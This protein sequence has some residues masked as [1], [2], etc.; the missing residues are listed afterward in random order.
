MPADADL[1]CEYFLSSQLSNS[2][3]S[4]SVKTASLAT[5]TT[6]QSS[7]NGHQHHHHHH[8]HTNGSTHNSLTFETIDFVKYNK[9]PMSDA[10]KL[11]YE[12][13]NNNNHHHNNN[14]SSTTAITN[15]SANTLN[16]NHSLSQSISAVG[17]AL[18]NGLNKSQIVN[19]KPVENG[20]GK[21]QQTS[22]TVSTTNGVAKA[23][24]SSSTPALDLTWSRIR[25]KGIGLLNLGNNCYLNATLQ[26]LAYTPPLSQWLVTRPHSPQ[27]R[28][29]VLKGF[30][31]LC[32]VERII[33]D[34]FNSAYGCAKPNSLCYNIKKISNLFGVGTQEDASEF[35][36]TLLEH[37]AKAIKFSSSSSPNQFNGAVNGKHNANNKRSHT[38]LD[39]IFAFQFRSRITCSSCGRLS[40]TIED[41]NIWPLEVK[42]VQDIR[43]GMLHFLKEEIL[44][45]ENA[46]K[47]EKCGRKTR[48]TKKYSIRSAP[49]ILVVHLK[50][51]DSSHV[52]KLSHYVA[53]PETLQLPGLVNNNNSMGLEGGGSGVQYKLYGVLVHLGYTSHSGH[54]YSYVRGPPH[55]QQWY[56]ADDTSVSAVSASDALAQNAYILFYSKVAPPPSSTPII[57]TPSSN[58]VSTSSSS[59]LSA[60]STPSTLN[61]HHNHVSL[62]FN[63][64]NSS[65]T[66]GTKLLNGNSNAP[67]STPTPSTS[68][69]FNSI[70]AAPRIIKSDDTGPSPAKSAR[71]EYG[72]QLPPTFAPQTATTTTTPTTNGNSAILNALKSNTI[73]SS[74][75]AKKETSTVV[76]T[77]GHHHH[78]HQNHDNHHNH[79]D[80]EKKSDAKEEK[81]ESSSTKSTKSSSSKKK[82]RRKRLKKL[83]RQ[84]RNGRLAPEDLTEKQMKLAKTKKE[85][86][87]LKKVLKRKSSN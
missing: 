5:T 76:T 39:D 17:S 9:N 50:R 80:D 49:N 63:H 78:H 67:T 73:S 33:F 58:S 83:L 75:S 64:H 81:K 6:T 56:K 65:L 24:A 11:K 12:V 62:H 20:V 79:D 30:C 53:Y 13:L 82:L 43:K 15:G 21:V 71:L 74:L 18:V 84:L 77:N 22:A 38:I 31:S 46:Y 4:S 34:I 32:E 27:C 59:L 68:K 66:N 55:G 37:M 7:Q 45:G 70:F 86:K 10:L 2:N 1:L 36:T 60:S 23:T 25:T 8:N 16:N 41:T 26:C 14:N 47:C 35:F 28:F 29:R 52:G 54:Y 72:P 57:P 69:Y 3:K 87:R 40:D 51:F 44:D 48:A 19:N 61:Q 42:Y 85:K